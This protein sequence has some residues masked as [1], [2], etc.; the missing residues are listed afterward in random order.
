VST[1]EPFQTLGTH[2]SSAHRVTLRPSF[3]QCAGSRFSFLQRMKSSKHA[4]N[5]SVIRFPNSLTGLDYRRTVV[6]FAVRPDEEGGALQGSTGQ[7]NFVD[8]GEVC[9]SGCRGCGAH[10][11]RPERCVLYLPTAVVFG[12]ADGSGNKLSELEINPPSLFHRR[13]S[14][15]VPTTS[16]NYQ[17]F[18]EI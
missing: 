3:K 16:F 14:H 8:M 2:R 12:V 15:F 11:R 1:K 4:K 6:L 18:F 17:V 10:R 9:R 5:Q 7:T 13:V